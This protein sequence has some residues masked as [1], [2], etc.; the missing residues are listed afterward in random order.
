M[1]WIKPSEINGTLAAPPS[2]SFMIRACAAALLSE[3]ES[4]IRMPTFCDDAQAALDIIHT[5][6]AEINIRDEKIKIQGR[7][8]I[9]NTELNCKESGL[10]L[11]LFAPIAS[12]SNT[13]I[14]L[15]ATGSL[16]TRPME[17]LEKP[18]RKLGGFCQTQGG[19][20]PVKVQGPISGGKIKID[21]S[22]SS[23][24]LTGFLMALPLC[25]Q[26]SEIEVFN[27]KSS[28]YMA[29]TQS[30]LQHFGITIS[31]EKNFRRIFIKGNQIYLPSEY[32]VEG[33]WSGAAFFLVAG[34][35]NG[36]A[37]LTNLNPNSLQ[38]DI[39]ILEALTSCGAE[40][41]RTDT[42]VTVK[43][44][45]LNAFDFDATECPDL[46]PPL[47]TLAVFCSGRSRITGVKRL[48]FKESD[49]ARVLETELTKIGAK[50]TLRGN[51]MEIEGTT[52]EGGVIDSFGDH[53]IAMTGAVAALQS[54]FGVRIQ[55]WQA[56]S[57][58]YPDFFEDLESLQGG[59]E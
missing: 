39:K 12:L 43:R 18:I 55:N 57:K 38:A 41:T 23:Q 19:Y 11:R 17:M 40:I 46:F 6:G 21:G 3:G 30:V 9:R 14:T 4:Q 54:K 24:V 29:M 28:P 47:T 27:L 37:T 26:D 8:S 58:S 34:A 7:K 42:S 1:K 53:R 35:V 44:K 13:K 49:R 32:T 31:Q 10:S 50:I 16:L 2:K 25:T 15:I 48:R 59:K 52:L 22:T 5:L 45:K 20:P 33:D 56:V 36:Q 51:T